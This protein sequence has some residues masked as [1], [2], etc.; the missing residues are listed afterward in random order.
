M[1]NVNA[2]DKR[3][4]QLT[5]I[6]A[7]IQRLLERKKKLESGPLTADERRRV[8]RQNVIVG[9]WLRANRSKLFD[10]IKNSLT[11]EQDRA[12]FGLP[13]AAGNQAEVEHKERS[14]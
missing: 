5:S 2:N 4:R 7:E 8:A 14:A 6:E 10:E 3:T 13:T 11:R 12:A 9:A 1:S